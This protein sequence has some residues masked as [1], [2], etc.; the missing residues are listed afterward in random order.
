MCFYF[1]Y[2]L[3]I[4]TVEILIKWNKSFYSNFVKPHCSAQWLQ[5]WSFVAIGNQIHNWFVHNFVCEIII[6]MK[7]RKQFRTQKQGLTLNLINLS[8]V[9]ICVSFNKK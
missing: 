5:P 4:C 9:L 7:D 2:G 3:Y 6:N 1:I 8:V